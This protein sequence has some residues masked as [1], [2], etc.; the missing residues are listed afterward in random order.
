[1]CVAVGVSLGVKVSVGVFDGVFVGV[2]VGVAKC[3]TAPKSQSVDARLLPIWS[4]EFAAQMASL[5]SSRTELLDE[6]G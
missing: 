4:V 3:S 2:F 6:S 1:M 5:P